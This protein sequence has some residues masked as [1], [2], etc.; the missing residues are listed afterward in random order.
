MDPSPGFIV[1]RPMPRSPLPVLIITYHEPGKFFEQNQTIDGSESCSGVLR[2][3][4]QAST[5][6]PEAPTYSAAL[7]GVLGIHTTIAEAVGARASISSI[8]VH[9][10]PF[11]LIS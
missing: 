11:W 5:S 9:K 4:R 10:H 1:I 2:V 7:Y 3:D 8:L 6:T